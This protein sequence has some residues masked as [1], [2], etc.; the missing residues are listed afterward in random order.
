MRKKAQVNRRPKSTRSKSIK[1]WAPSRY[2]SGKLNTTIAVLGII[3]LVV[4]GLLALRLSR[5]QKSLVRP[6]GTVITETPSTRVSAYPDYIYTNTKYNYS[7]TLPPQPSNALPLVIVSADDPK[8]DPSSLCCLVIIR[9]GEPNKRLLA[10]VVNDS[11][12]FDWTTSRFTASDRGSNPFMDEQYRKGLI[13]KEGYQQFRDSVLK[14]FMF[15]N[16]SAITFESRN[17]RV[18]VVRLKDKDMWISINKEDLLG[19]RIFSRFRF[20]K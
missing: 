1:R 9:N 10:I 18:V 16:H 13:S 2:V 20:N 6:S 7:I 4:L 8:V 12:G 14:K 17:V 15:Q 3:L 11:T 19:D 5:P